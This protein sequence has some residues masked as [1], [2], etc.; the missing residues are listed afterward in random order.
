MARPLRITYPGALYHVT[1]RGNERKPIFRDCRDRQCFLDRVAAVASR[2]RLVLHAYVL[3]RN[4]Y[5]L[6]VATPEGNLSAALRHLNGAYTQDFNV[7]T[8]AAGTCFRAVT[9]AYWSRRTPIW[10]S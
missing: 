6:L 3:M 8:G 10:W 7:A 1:T 2:Y 4:H 9:R 5:H